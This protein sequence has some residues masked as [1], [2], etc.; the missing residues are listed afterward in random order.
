MNQA[1]VSNLGKRTTK[2]THIDERK[3]MLEAMRR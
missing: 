1:T 2:Q 3:E